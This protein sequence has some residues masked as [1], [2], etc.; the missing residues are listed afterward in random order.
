M[1]PCFSNWPT[2][3]LRHGHF[4]TNTNYKRETGGGGGGGVGGGVS[5]RAMRIQDYKNPFH[6]PQQTLPAW[7]HCLMET[8][9]LTT[10]CYAM[11]Q[12]KTAWFFFLVADLAFSKATFKTVHVILYKKNEKRRKP[13]DGIIFKSSA[14]WRYTQISYFSLAKP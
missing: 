5:R 1:G 4:F 12:N 7:L 13:I 3:D 10:A 2:N 11:E 14:Q 8:Q 9:C 6:T